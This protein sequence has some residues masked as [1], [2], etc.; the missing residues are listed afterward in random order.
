M[1]EAMKRKI[2]TQ[3]EMGGRNRFAILQEE[4][5]KER[6]KR[7]WNSKQQNKT[8]K[9]RENENSLNGHTAEKNVYGKQEAEGK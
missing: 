7:K 8:Q 5:R 4:E 6:R 1:K 9:Q 2:E 3:Q